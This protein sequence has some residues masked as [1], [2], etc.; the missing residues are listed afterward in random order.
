MPYRPMPMPKVGKMKKSTTVPLTPAQPG[1]RSP[2]G[3]RASAGTVPAPL[4]GR[5]GGVK[6][7][8][9]GTAGAPPIAR[10]F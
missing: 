10:G 7:S 1:V 6:R 4:G 3:S 9:G 2:S 8:P 5:P